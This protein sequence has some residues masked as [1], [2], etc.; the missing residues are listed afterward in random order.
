MLI[1]Y[2]QGR[3]G[4]VK[5]RGINSQTKHIHGGGPQGGFFGILEY[6]S[7]S[8]YNAEMVDPEEKV[9]FVDDLTLLE[10]FN[11]ISIGMS[12]FN[13]KLNVPSDIPTHN[14]FIHSEHL[15][16]QQYLNDIT[17][18]TNKKI[19]KINTNKTK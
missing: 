19:M 17:N 1:S 2:F 5:W 11:L 13:V 16:T 18:W 4:F 6:L 10:I 15:K 3:K 8:N 12:C 9:N 14:G 7:Q